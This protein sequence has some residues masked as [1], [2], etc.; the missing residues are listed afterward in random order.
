M[1]D[2]Y[3]LR[4]YGKHTLIVFQTPSLI[5]AADVERVRTDLVRMVDEEKR[6]H[7][8]IDFGKVQFLSSQVLGLLLTLNKKLTGTLAGGSHVV[9]CGVSPPLLELLKISRLDRILTIKATRKEAL[10]E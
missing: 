7:F 3:K 8:V 9:L 1:D 6:T 4:Q 5:N 2:V 10:K